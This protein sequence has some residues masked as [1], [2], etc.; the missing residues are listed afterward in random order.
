MNAA[1]DRLRDR[2][3][4]NRT[5]RDGAA[6]P[7]LTISDCPQARLGCT[8]IAGDR[9]FDRVTGE[10]GI[11]IGGTRENLVVSTPGR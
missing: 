3:L 4:Q 10:E 8:F 9:V 1:L 5:P 11:V 2:M 6:A 7:P